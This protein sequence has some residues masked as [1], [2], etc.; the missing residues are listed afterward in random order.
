MQTSDRVV[1]IPPQGV[2]P[3]PMGVAAQP[4]PIVQGVNQVQPIVVNQVTPAVAVVT[5][6]ARSSPYLTICPF[7]QNQVM[8]LSTLQ[9]NCCTCCLCW[10]TGFVCFAIIQACRGK[11]INCYDAE[12]KCPMCGKTIGMYNSC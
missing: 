6:A 8:T 5:P 4:V 7:C 10:C 12:H 9:F 2:Q 1:N 11:D 3:M